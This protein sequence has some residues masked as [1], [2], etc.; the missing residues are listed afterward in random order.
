M[1]ATGNPFMGLIAKPPRRQPAVPVS[2]RVIDGKKVYGNGPLTRNQELTAGSALTP[3]EAADKAA[4]E[5]IARKERA[6]AY[7]RAYHAARK[8]DPE[9][10]AK[11]RQRERDNREQLRAYRDEW[12]AA[13]ADRYRQSQTEWARRRRAS[14]TPEQREEEARRARERYAAMPPE[15]KA[16]HLAKVRER[17]RRNRSKAKPD[18]Q[19]EHTHG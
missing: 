7:N 10:M 15:K 14:L 9:Y 5:A 13:N 18:T 19:P 6:R 2:A 12:K 11:R 4:A 8:A 17:M 3:A 1:S 16:E